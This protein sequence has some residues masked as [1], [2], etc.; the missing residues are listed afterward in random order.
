MLDVHSHTGLLH[1]GQGAQ[2]R[3]FYAIEQAGAIALLDLGIQR[4][5]QVDSRSGTDHRGLSSQPCA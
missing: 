4:V 1:A 2:Q 5:C 3:E